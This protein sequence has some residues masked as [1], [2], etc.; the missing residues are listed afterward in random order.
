MLVLMDLVSFHILLN[1]AKINYLH[2]NNPIHL[3]INTKTVLARIKD[4]R[5]VKAMRLKIH[6][7][8]NH[9]GIKL[10]VLISVDL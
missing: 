4:R 8:Y 6:T 9:K 3:H 10:K 5:T 1:M 2:R 7:L